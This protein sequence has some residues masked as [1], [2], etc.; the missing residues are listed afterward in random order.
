MSTEQN[1]D[2]AR[3]IVEG[4][5]RGDLNV[6]DELFAEEYVD[7]GTPPGVPPGREGL[8]QSLTALRAT[9]PD[10]T[11]TIED[12]VAEGDRVVHRVTGRGTM[13]GELQGMPPTGKQAV[14]QEFHIG[15]FEGGK[16]VEHWA[17]VDQLGMMQQLNLAGYG[18]GG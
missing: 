7:Y 15:R 3:R 4:I 5:S 13:Q 1:K 12:E 17:I 10:F 6:I 11:Y 14:W 16:L 8:R 2:V 9:F 18:I